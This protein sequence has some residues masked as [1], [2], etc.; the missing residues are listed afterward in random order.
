M[1]YLQAVWSE[2]QN[3]IGYGNGAAQWLLYMAALVL[4]VFYGK[5]C[6]K[7]LVYPSVLILFFFFN[8]FFFKYIGMKFLAGV[9]WR[10]LWMLPIVFVTAFAITK[11]AYRFQKQAV[12]VVV[13]LLACV[14]IV[15]TGKPV[16]SSQ[17]YSEKENDYELPQAAIEISDIVQARLVDWKET[18]IVPN[19]LLCSIRQYSAAACLL[20]GRNAEGYISDIEEAEQIVYEEMCKENP[21]VEV[22]TQIAREKNCRYIVFNTDFHQIPED[23]TAYGYKKTDV[24]QNHY[25]VYSRIEG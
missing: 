2:F 19:E 21:D 6:R 23:L 8:P 3:F 1:I 5:R 14:C 22:I 12:R 24:V 17:T 9:Y 25:A 7:L 16:F 11:L 10:L 13:L 18:I 15:M 20:Y 4:C